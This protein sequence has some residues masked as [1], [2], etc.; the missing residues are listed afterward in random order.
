MVIRALVAAFA[1]L[2]VSCGG[3]DGEISDAKIGEF[4]K[5]AFE[6]TR[7]GASPIDQRFTLKNATPLDIDALVAFIPPP[8]RVDFEDTNFDETLGATVVT[9]LRI[10][11]ATDEPGVTIG[12]LELFGV[13]TAAFQS[14]FAP[15]DA[16]GANVLKLFDKIRL[17]DIKPLAADASGAIEALEIATLQVE[18][19][20]FAGERTEPLSV[21]KGLQLTGLYAKGVDFAGKTETGDVGLKVK[22][23]RLSEFGGGRLKELAAYDVETRAA[24]P[25]I[26]QSPVDS[27]L[28]GAMRIA[29]RPQK[30]SLAAFIWRDF[31]AAG[32]L[33]YAIRE[34]EPPANAEGLLRLGSLRVEDVAVDIDGTEAFR[35][36]LTTMQ[37]G[38]SIGIIPQSIQA[39]SIDGLYNLL[40][41]APADATALRDLIAERGIETVAAEGAFDWTWDAKSGDAA[42]D[43]KSAA[44]GLLAFENEIML[45]GLD[46]EALNA[47]MQA[48]DPNLAQSI[49]KLDQLRFFLR[50]D[51]F[52]DLAFAIASIETGGDGA[53]LRGSAPAIIR[54]A[55]AQ[56]FF[57]SPALAGYINSFA[58][59][60]ELGGELEIELAPED[61]VSLLTI[62]QIAE[63]EPLKLGETLGVSVK[64]RRK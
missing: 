53:A 22:D 56:A 8:L 37:A 17:F 10:R 40:A 1:L 4:E 24:A 30:T 31:D 64:H 60:V 16:G 15:A 23:F 5:A 62:S 12:R 2:L 41:Y 48:N 39:R 55:S 20:L 58:S 49:V 29:G 21:I 32:L 26:G 18:Q 34:E 25:I 7:A 3:S 44:E 35:G 42:L 46:P 6:P 47:A 51:A 14:A 63:K 13:D 33:D 52:L 11:G 38:P 54:L 28:N 57:V 27:A 9:G 59:F 45:S 19:G 61:P 50:D 43:L 36:A